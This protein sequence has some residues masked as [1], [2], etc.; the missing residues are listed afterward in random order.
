M[1]TCSV[2]F[3]L[4]VETLL[5]WVLA[6]FIIINLTY[7]FVSQIKITKDISKDYFSNQIYPTSFGDIQ[8]MKRCKSAVYFRF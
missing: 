5:R 4:M 2:L 8:Y 3:I 6:Y 7:L 1:F